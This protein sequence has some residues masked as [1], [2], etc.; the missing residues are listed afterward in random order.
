MIIITPQYYFNSFPSFLPFLLASF[1]PFFSP[2]DASPAANL[3]RPWKPP[4]KVKDL[5]AAAALRDA[6]SSFWTA[7]GEEPNFRRKWFQRN[8]N[9]KERKYSLSI[10][11]FEILAK[12]LQQR[13]EKFL[14][15]LLLKALWHRQGWQHP[16]SGQW[17]WHQMK[18]KS[19]FNFFQ[20][21]LYLVQKSVR[22]Q[23]KI[24]YL[25]R[26]GGKLWERIGSL[27]VKESSKKYHSSDIKF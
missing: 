9:K 1:L 21:S 5:P 7:I 16:D 12:K 13:F 14:L 10:L 11:K 6:T 20:W 22:N 27:S 3:Q 23:R 8:A 26:Q 4:S 18:Y 25:S 24:T 2:A 15:I 17:I 19:N